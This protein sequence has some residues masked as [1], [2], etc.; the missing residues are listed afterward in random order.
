M[1]PGFPPLPDPSL[2]GLPIRLIPDKLLALPLAPMLN[3]LFKASIEE[4]DF[5]FL[6]GH[7]LRLVIA[8]IDVSTCLGFDG[9]R[10]TICD[11]RPCDVEFRGNISAFIL[12]VTRQQDPDTLFFQ[13]KLM[14]EG[15]TELGLGIKNLL[16]GVELEQLPVELRTLFALGN[17]VQEKVEQIIRK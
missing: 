5:D 14:I 17:K 13:R 7:W 8:D 12:L 16:Y 10:L 1:I 2:L 11:T 3:R 4:G 9:S 15:D 6:S